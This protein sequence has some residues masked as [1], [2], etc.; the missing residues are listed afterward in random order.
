M[1]APDVTV[2]VGVLVGGTGVGVLVDVAVGVLVST[3]VGVLVGVGVLVAV[4]VL[5]G[6]RVGVTV[7]EAVGVLV[8][9]GVPVGVGVGVGGTA[10]AVLVGV[11]GG[12]PDG[13]AGGSDAW[14]SS[15][16]ADVGVLERNAVTPATSLVASLGG[17]TL[18]AGDAPVLGVSTNAAIRNGPR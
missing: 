11:I 15:F 2:A 9:I 7:G 16:A 13:G 3:A 5:V 17:V 1:P 4:G 14:R 6:V 10:E 18:A 8:G 12:R